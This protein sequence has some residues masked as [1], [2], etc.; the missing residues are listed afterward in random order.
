MG[1]TTIMAEGNDAGDSLIPAAANFEGR[2]EP[3]Q[4]SGYLY[5]RSSH[6]VRPV[7]SRRFFSLHDNCLEY[8]TLE[9][10]NNSSTVA[11]DLRLCTV[12]RLD[13]P[14]RRHCFEI[15]SPVKYCKSSF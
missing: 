4:K 8:Y 11:I 3:P 1:P 10:K 12:K 2:E 14:E 6:T 9:G 5:K 7:W 15:V 13:L